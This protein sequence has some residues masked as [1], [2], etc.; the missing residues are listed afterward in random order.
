MKIGII[1]GTSLF[2]AD[3]LNNVKKRIIETEFGDAEIYEKEEL[4]FI[5]R[6]GDKSIPP[7]KINCKANISALKEIG[8]KA[9]ISL[10][11]TGS[12]KQDISPGT[13]LIPE[14]FI[15]FYEVPTIFD[16]EI[17]HIIPSFD[18]ELRQK[19]IAA[20]KKIEDI[21]IKDGGIY[22]QTKGPRLETAAEIRFF[23]NFADVI[24]MTLA[25][26]VTIANELRMPLA[27]ICSIDNYCNGI[28]N[29]TLEYSHIRQSAQENQNKVLTLLTEAIA[30]INKD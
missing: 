29:Q 8:V 30:E 28:N 19:I 16:N 12:L 14:D 23:K 3:I 18:L 24:G 10:T 13:I 22:L 26:E 5:Q 21:Q 15:S 9:I 6:H 2:K 17:N 1:G 4:V 20:S 7:H 11:S 25:S 27:A